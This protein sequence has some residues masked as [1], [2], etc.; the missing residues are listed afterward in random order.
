MNIFEQASRKQIRFASNRGELLTEQ[1][2]S[3]PLQSKT[4]CDLDTI[5]KDVNKSLRDVTDDS[6]V[7][8]KTNPAKPQLELKLEILKHI[9][10]VK[11]AEAEASA[12]AVARA[13]Q[14]SKLLNALAEQED[15]ALKAMTPEQLR[16]QLQE[17]EK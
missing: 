6:F 13:Q 12:S 2:W 17:L 5:A 4:Q 8:T 9:I 3:L 10:A 1:L 11:Q 15:N 7:S 16:A 14:R